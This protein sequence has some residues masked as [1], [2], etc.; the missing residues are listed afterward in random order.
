MLAH[1]RFAIDTNVLVYAATVDTDP[2][3]EQARALIAAA[4]ARDTVLPFQVL[5]ELTNTLLRRADASR[6]VVV[7]TIDKLSGLFPMIFADMRSYAFGRAAMLR[8]QLSFWDAQ[9]L[10]VCAHNSVSHLLTE[11]GHHGQ[12]LGGVTLVNPFALG[13]V[14]EALEWP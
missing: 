12:M 7:Q 11:D 13:S 14:E 3:C 6:E 2:R 8:H 9:I 10:A 4:A 1:H 5:R